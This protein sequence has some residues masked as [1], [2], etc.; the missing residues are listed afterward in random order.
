MKE[1]FLEIAILLEKCEFLTEEFHY[2]LAIKDK[3]L[4]IIHENCKNSSFGYYDFA[5]DL[6]NLFISI[7][8]IKIKFLTQQIKLEEYI[9]F[10]KEFEKKYIQ[11][12]QEFYLLIHKDDSEFSDNEIYH[13]HE[14]LR[15]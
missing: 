12:R 6:L 7:W 9:H 13:M 14:R 4:Y 10:Q 2:F 5:L 3:I 11:Y 1:K 8:N 15:E